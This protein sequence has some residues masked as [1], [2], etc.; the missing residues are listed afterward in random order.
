MAK[1]LYYVGLRRPS[2]EW[3]FVGRDDGKT[4][5]VFMCRSLDSLPCDLRWYC[6]PLVTTKAYWRE[7]AAVLLAAFNKDHGTAY[8]RLV[9]K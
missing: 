7:N 6:G 1:R 2:D 5:H 9:I 3:G 8:T 4:L